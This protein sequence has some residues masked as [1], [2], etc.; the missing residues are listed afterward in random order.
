MVFDFYPEAYYAAIVI[1]LQ[2][3]RPTKRM[4]EIKT[5][6]SG[7]H[8]LQVLKVEVFVLLNGLAVNHTR[9]YPG[10]IADCKMFRGNGDWHTIHLKRTDSGTT[11]TDTDERLE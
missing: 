5:Y 10:S 8:L 4:K 9:V 2:C 1:I 6:Y 7:K 3:F 11:Y